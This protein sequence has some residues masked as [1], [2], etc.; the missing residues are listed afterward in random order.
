VEIAIRDNGIGAKETELKQMFER[1]VS[2]KPAASHGLA[3]S[4]SI[5]EDPVAVLAESWRR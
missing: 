5:V 4:R 3:I 2:S 1:F